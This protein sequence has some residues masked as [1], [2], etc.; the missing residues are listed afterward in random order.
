MA[1]KDGG[2]D[3]AKFRRRNRITPTIAP[4]SG[5]SRMTYVRIPTVKE[6]CELDPGALDFALSEQVEHLSDLL[7][8]AEGSAA[9]FFGR[10][11]VTQGM[12]RLLREGLQ[13][14]AGS[15]SQAVFE[16]RQAMGG[17]KTHT[18]LALGLLARNPHLYD[19]VP[20]TVTQGITGAKARVVAINGRTVSTD[21]F[22]WGDIARQL[23]KFETFS[24]FWKDGADAPREDDWIKLIGDEPTLILLDEL[25]P[26]IE[27]A[28]TRPVGG[29]TLAEVTTYALSNLLSAA[30]KLKRTAIVV[31]NLTGSYQGATQALAATFKNIA[32]ETKRQALPIT[33]VDLNTNE[34]YEIVRKRM[35]AKLPEREE[36]EKVAEAYGEAI[37]RA[38]RS[39]TIA[40]SP[41]QIADE[42][43]GAY[44]FHPS[45]K[46]IIALFKENENYRQTRGLMQ[47]VS[48]MLKSVWQGKDVGDVYLIGCQHLDLTISDVRD[49]VN[50]IGDLEGAMTTDVSAADGSAHAQAIAATRG[51]PAATQVAKLLLTASLSQSV[52]AVKGLSEASLIEYLIVPDRSPS[53]FAEA[54]AELQT[55]CWYLHRKTND[56]WYFSKVE[57]LRKRVQNRAVGAPAGRIE[58][59]LKRRLDNAFA[60][61]SKRAYAHA[62]ALPLIDEI[63]IEATG[64]HCLVMSPDSRTPPEEALT[65][66]NSQTYKNGFC[67]VTGDGSSMGNI[68]EKVRQIWAVE[69]VRAELGDSTTH[70]A[71]LDELAESAE[72]EFGS[73]LTTLFN[74]VYFPMPTQ[75]RKGTRLAHAPLKLSVERKDVKGVVTHE[76]NGEAAVEEALNPEIGTK[77]LIIDVE[78]SVDMLVPRA[79]DMLWPETQSR[80]LWSDVV[81]R[82]QSNARWS[83]LPPKG[84][85]TLR[86]H[87]VS[88]GR[89]THDGDGYVDKAPPKPRTTANVI[90]R[91]RSDQTGTAEL[92]IVPQN[93]GKKPDILMSATGNFDADGVPL[94]RN[95]FSTDATKL[96]FLVKDPDGAHEQ[97]DAVA[98]TNTIT[99]T[100]QPQ[101]I[102]GKRIVTLTAV[103]R[104][105]IRWNTDGTNPKEG[106]VYDGPIELNG[107]SAITI[108]AYALDQGVATEKEFAIAGSE[109]ERTIDKT[110]KATLKREITA[111]GTA[112][113]FK[114]IEAAEANKAKLV[115]PRLTI[116]DG[117]KNIGIRIG[118][119]V[120]V[121]PEHFRE[122]VRVCRLAIGDETATVS[123]SF[124]QMAFSTGY[125][126]EQF[127]QA[128]GEDVRVT[129]VEQ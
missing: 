105:E 38:V 115:K 77:K 75:D 15:S 12:A 32:E 28:K 110:R 96:W 82:A 18:M 46:N 81:R 60:P 53:E 119:A 69:K 79:E 124:P 50:R 93:A 111:R 1:Y 56:V 31:S 9:D 5:H 30:M 84:L 100:H 3:V 128:L 26:Y 51:N 58:A 66:L 55:A 44:P 116:G 23:G 120:E 40:R 2:H 45:V 102:P 108:Y 89:W 33:P 48:K 127:A 57:N 95:P 65:F 90:V 20:A 94:E 13:R 104:G 87:A 70:K 125:D 74:R 17:G 123:G 54:F 25:P 11:H 101:F 106:A 35:F 112:E 114:A 121:A 49:E 118:D 68:D 41:E 6:A 43:M 39:K 129:D 21:H 42:V 67:V 80:I 76:I 37:G 14:L 63:V 113:V 52:E 19:Q 83:W 64:R 88:I 98:W 34:I 61:R 24:K 47:F 62:K 72:F 78:G 99:L 59:E 8:E 85:E 29:A 109:E 22:L 4:L 92:E 73:T 103:P 7:D 122:L 10:N 16:L 107:K 97:G 71:E 36:I 117:S 91:S 126:L 86:D 27:F